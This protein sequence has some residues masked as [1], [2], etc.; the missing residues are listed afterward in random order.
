MGRQYHD[1]KMGRD[2]SNGIRSKINRYN[3]FFYIFFFFSKIYCPQKNLQ[4]Y[5]STTVGDCG[6]VL[7]PC[8]TMLAT[9]VGVQS[10]LK[11]CNFF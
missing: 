3:G 9:A 10:V 4:N 6:R 8:P 7:P 5:T 2:V 1:F 11:V